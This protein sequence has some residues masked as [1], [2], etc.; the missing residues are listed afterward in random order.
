MADI[1]IMGAGLGGAI[2][3]YEMKDQMRR[4]DK[5]TVV[6]KDP[7]YHFVPSNPWVASAG[8]KRGA[9]EVNLASTFAKRGI[10]FKPSP[11]TKL[12][13]YENT[14]ETA[15]GSTL[16]YDYLIIATGPELAFDEVEG[17]GPDASA[18]RSATSTMRRRLRS[19]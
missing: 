4:E 10:D 6:T 9:L 8:E 2:M 16:R 13:S 18:L 3:A 1:V 11:V 17:L 15:D 5:L 7:I 14:F 12:S 19:S